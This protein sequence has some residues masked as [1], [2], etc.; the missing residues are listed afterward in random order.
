MIYLVLFI[1][2]CQWKLITA[3]TL[4]DDNTYGVV[5]FNTSCSESVVDYFNTATSM[6]YSFWYSESLSSYLDIID[7]DSSCCMAYWGAAMTYNHPVW[8]YLSDER[9]ETASQYSKQA[10]ECADNMSGSI[11]DR[12]IAYIKALM[13]YYD[14]TDPELNEPAVRLQTYANAFKE[15]VYQ[16]YG[17]TDENAGIIYGL[18]MI[19]VGYYS[20]SEPA[21]GFPNL[22]LA[23]LT[24]ELVLLGNS[25]SPGALHYIIHSYDQ[26]TTSH[27]ALDAAYTYWN[28]SVSVPHALH[29]P[30]HI[31]SD[32]GLWSD[33]VASN[34]DSLNLAFAQGNCPTGDWYHGSF[35]LQFGMLQLAMDC[36]AKSFMNSLQ[37]DLAVNYP[38]NFNAEAGVRIPT[39]YLVETRSWE[40]AAH[41]D[42]VNWYST[43]PSSLWTSNP[44]SLITSNFVVT[45]ARAILNYCI[46]EISAAR[47]AVDDANRLLL[48][49]PDWEKR[50]LP[51]WR[52]S[53]TVMV[54]SAHAWETYRLVSPLAGIEA[55][56]QVVEY[57]I[58]TW[59]PEIAHAWDSREQLAEML[60]MHYYEN[61]NA[62]DS[63]D[64]ENVRRAL[65]AYEDAIETYP[66]RFH[67]IA[68]AAKCSDILGNSN[69]ASNYYSQL[70]LL[71]QPPFPDTTTE[72]VIRESCPISAY[73]RYRRPA[74]VAAE[75]YFNNL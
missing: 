69:K 48:S 22:G 54:D 3:N 17:S 72:G 59:A 4:S 75:H 65:Q 39:M 7:Q 50:Q 27:R 16:P 44:W 70:L 14:T 9:L 29:M 6:L 15:L 33:M 36:D 34:I 2:L 52:N 46:E 64:L 49:D 40:D 5:N 26:P 51:Y 31:F 57:Q 24:E 74:L 12:E 62:T 1:T 21:Q 60:L 71:T 20:E 58:N 8:D 61:L 32:M 37:E 63:G 18:A 19:G 30:S 41:F 73:S 25:Q 43:I 47:K 42:L 28:V 38:D 35:F 56:E 13:I 10:S 23:G 67:S 66:N 11:S 68:G 53:F 55:M 45:A